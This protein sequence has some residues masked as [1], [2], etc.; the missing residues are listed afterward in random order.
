ML[1]KELAKELLKY[2]DFKVKMSVNRKLSEGF[3]KGMQYP[4]PLDSMECECEMDDIGYSDRVFI[5][6]CE[7]DES[8]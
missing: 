3:L 1:A 6:G 7:V 5:L 4:Y 2:P 8:F